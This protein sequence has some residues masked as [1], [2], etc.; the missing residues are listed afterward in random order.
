MEAIA[1][2][3]SPKCW[4]SDPLLDV[5]LLKVLDSLALFDCGV[6]HMVSTHSS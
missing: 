1:T 6:I 5:C 3:N 2:A 4:S